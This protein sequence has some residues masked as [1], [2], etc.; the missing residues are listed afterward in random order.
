MSN[1]SMNEEPS[2]PGMRVT[3]SARSASRADSLPVIR[4][5]RV[6]SSTVDLRVGVSP[7]HPPDQ[8]RGQPGLR[9]ALHVIDQANEEFAAVPHAVPVRGALAFVRTAQ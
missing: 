1:M 5:L 2:S 6:L 7:G 4:V 9:V 8:V 3:P